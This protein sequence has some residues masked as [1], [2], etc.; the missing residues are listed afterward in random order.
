MSSREVLEDLSMLGAET[1]GIE[2]VWLMVVTWESAW[3]LNLYSFSFSSAL[4][5]IASIFLTPFSCISFNYVHF[6]FCFDHEHCEARSHLAW[7]DCRFDWRQRPG[8][9]A[10]EPSSL[11][12][13][14]SAKCAQ[15]HAWPGF[16]ARLFEW[17]QAVSKHV[18]FRSCMYRLGIINGLLY[19]YV[20]SNIHHSHLIPTLNLFHSLA[21]SNSAFRDLDACMH[22][23]IH[24][25][26][27]T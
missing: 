22:T 15:A 9:L 6:H 4:H 7:A 21:V 25:Y 13:F 17:I 10:T 2:F 26:L 12:Q 20:R 16:N 14:E 23:C 11:C 5:I 27:D 1:V 19:M 18:E 24:R 3:V 8:Q